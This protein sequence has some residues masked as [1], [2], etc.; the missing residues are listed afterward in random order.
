MVPSWSSLLNKI[1]FMT[2]STEDTILDIKMI[3][4]EIVIRI[5]TIKGKKCLFHENMKFITIWPCRASQLY[6]SHARKDSRDQARDHCPCSGLVVIISLQKTLISWII[7]AVICIESWG[8]VRFETF[9][10]HLEAV[11][12]GKLWL[13]HLWKRLEVAEGQKRAV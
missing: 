11:G 9:R 8:V 7:G 10:P 5:L 2:G 12:C 13:I 4:F 6:P 3:N 1:N